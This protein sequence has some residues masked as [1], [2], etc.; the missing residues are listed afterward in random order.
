MELGF[1]AMDHQT[2]TTISHWRYDAPYDFYNMEGD[3]VNELVNGSYFAVMDDSGSL[4]GF[5]CVGASAQVPAG[6]EQGAYTEDGFVDVGLGM[7]PDLT[8]KG[9]GFEFISAIL[10]RID[11]MYGGQHQRLTVAT[12]NTRGIRLYEKVGFVSCNRFW[13]GDVEF[14]TMKRRL[15]VGI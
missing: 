12:F 6:N 10:A 7:R 4:V 2:A 14:M 11:E 13:N 9:L 15:G 5:F 1:Q 8:G 3:D